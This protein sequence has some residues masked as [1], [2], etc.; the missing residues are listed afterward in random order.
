M[1]Y[2]KMLSVRLMCYN[3]GKYISQ[4][5][6]GILNQKTS[7]DFEIVVGDDYSTDNTYNIL[8]HYVE[9]Y[10]TL[11]KILP[12][13][14]NI[15]RHNNFVDILNNCQGKYIALLDGDDYWTDPL[16]LQKQVDFLEENPD[17]ALCFH[18][19]EIKYEN[20][21]KRNKVFSNTSKQKSVT[22]QEDL[23]KGNYIGTPSCVVRNGLIKRFPSWFY[24]VPMADWPY[25]LLNAQYGKIKFLPE[26][27]GVYRV[28]NEGVWRKFD[29]IVRLEKSIRACEIMYENFTGNVR[30]ILI[31]RV[32]YNS[33]KISLHYLYKRNLL[34]HK[35]YYYLHKSFLLKAIK[36]KLKIFK[37]DY[38][39]I[40][41]GVTYIMPY[42]LFISFYNYN[43][44]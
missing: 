26:T 5:I 31:D 3:Q 14:S 37:I 30:M 42:K 11:F 27:M 33:L 36:C 34:L 2:D 7:F 25:H 18:N 35:K 43:K 38:G 22:T 12:R 13:K 20:K 4:A 15:G 40:K 44:A 19:M 23:A 6:E 21:Y 10:N 41:N 28:H 29:K 32:I 24:R 17:F 9:K 39:L 1:K 8:Q 16:K